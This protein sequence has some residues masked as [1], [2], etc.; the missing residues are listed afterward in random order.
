MARIKLYP[1]QEK[2]LKETETLNKVAYYHD[3]GLGKTFTG[4][5]KLI[6]LKNNV[7]L[8]VCQKSKISDWYDHF[9]N[10]YDVSVFNL[11]KKNE[12]KS[13]IEVL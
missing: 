2:E 4:A 5:E 6:R 8:V 10:Y 1:H 3:M 12:L 7:N 11:T 13:F 9:N